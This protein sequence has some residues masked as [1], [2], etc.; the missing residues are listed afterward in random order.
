MACLTDI[1]HNELLQYKTKFQNVRIENENLQKEINTINN[2]LISSKSYSDN[3]IKHLEEENIVLKNKKNDNEN[4][5]NYKISS[6]E[7]IINE[8]SNI[9]VELDAR[10]K[11]LENEKIIFQN[12]ANDLHSKLV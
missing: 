6:L 2:N 10:I 3:I 7:K 1:E 11:I 12:D 9:I 8:K 4:N 5:L